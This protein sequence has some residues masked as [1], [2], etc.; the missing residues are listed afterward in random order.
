MVEK[1]QGKFP[2]EVKKVLHGERKE[3]KGSG[4]R[5]VAEERTAILPLV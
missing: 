5:Q 3:K 1:V 2:K 4:R